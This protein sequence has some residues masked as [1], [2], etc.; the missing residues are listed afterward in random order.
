MYVYKTSELDCSDRPP[1]IK[2]AYY[3][4]FEFEAATYKILDLKAG[5]GFWNLEVLHIQFYHYKPIYGET[6]VIVTSPL[7]YLKSL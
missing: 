6:D 3:K 5:A 4:G 7:F 2:A 1:K